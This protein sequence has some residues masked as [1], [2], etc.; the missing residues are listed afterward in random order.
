M[1]NART[2]PRKLIRGIIE[3]FDLSQWLTNGNTKSPKNPE[4]DLGEPKEDHR[5]LGEP[6]NGHGKL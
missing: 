5:N 2:K 6:G 1:K 4:N 3:N